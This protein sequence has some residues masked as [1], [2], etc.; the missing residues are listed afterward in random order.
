MHFSFS[1]VFHVANNVIINLG[2]SK[3][4]TTIADHLTICTSSSNPVELFT[5]FITLYSFRI[6]LPL[7]LFQ[8]QIASTV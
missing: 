3:G 1:R 2:A 4:L 8:T 5:E 7:F 6:R